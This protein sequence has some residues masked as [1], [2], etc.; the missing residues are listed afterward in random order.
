VTETWT[1]TLNY[2]DSTDYTFTNTFNA[3]IGLYQICALTELTNDADPSNDMV[4][5][6][7]LSTG[8]D[9]ITENGMKLWQNVPNPAEGKTI[10]SYEIPKAGMVRFR[11]VD[12]FGKTVLNIEEDAVPGRH[13][14]DIDAKK[15]SAG[16]YYYTM[17]FDD[18]QLTRKMI[19]NH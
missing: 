4:C 8:F 17:Y 5:K 2:G 10:I 7:V 1:G 11:V 14:I 13:Q 18:Y 3:P 9:E 16:V 6:T 12:M 15:L 19:I